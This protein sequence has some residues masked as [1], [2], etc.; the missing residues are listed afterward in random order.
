MEY[1]KPAYIGLTS[2]PPKDRKQIERLISKAEDDFEAPGLDIK[3]LKMRDQSG[4]PTY[5][6]R[7]KDLRVILQRKTGFIEVLDIINSN[8]YSQY[9]KQ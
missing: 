8:Q 5:V 2:L 1:A 3:K 6:L 7:Y 4:Q 9:T